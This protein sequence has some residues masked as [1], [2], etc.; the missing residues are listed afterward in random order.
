MKLK[1]RVYQRLALT[2]TVSVGED[3]HV[4]PNSRIW[5]PRSLT[6]GRDVYVGKNVTIEVDGTIGPGVLIANNVGIVG[7]RDHDQRQ[8]GEFISKA[9]WVGDHQDL[10][11]P[12]A[13]GRDV[14]I[15]F[16]A[17]VLSGT[18]IG[19]SSVIAAGAVV[20]TDVPENSIVSG[21]PAK[22]VSSRYSDSEFAKHNSLLDDRALE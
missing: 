14:W 20:T 12:I 2:P 9:R 22:A 6:I 8:V 15:G 13:I 5:A 10:S 17:V 21:N 7:R 4:G 3:F 11:L 1:Q 18:T 16:G 19:R